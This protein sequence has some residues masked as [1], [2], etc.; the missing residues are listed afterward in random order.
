MLTFAFILTVAATTFAAE[1]EVSFNIT[2]SLNKNF[3]KAENV[4]WTV[5]KEFVKANFT[6]HDTNV[7]A[8]Y[9]QD[10]DLIGMGRAIEK[11]RLPLA[12]LNVIDQKYADYTI[13]DA[14]EFTYTDKGT[15][16]YVAANNGTV[17][18][19][20]NI[21]VEGEVTVFKKEKL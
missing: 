14:V 11:D 16:Y 1:N 20:L 15:S 9:T 2:K 7:E 18:V 5:K 3:P 6:W 19:I 4:K 13:T 17:K 8:Y 12:S 10:G 21:S